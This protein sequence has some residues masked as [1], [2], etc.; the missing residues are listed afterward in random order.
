[1]KTIICENSLLLCQKVAID[2]RDYINAH[3]GSL[4]CL[5]AGDTP[6][7]AY[8][9]LI[10][11]AKNREVDLN[12]VFYVG[13]DEWLGI[14]IETRGSC[15]QVMQEN[16]YGP[17][18]IRLENMLLWD[19]LCKNPQEEINRVMK[20]VKMHGGID[21]VL[22]GIGMNGHIGLNEPGTDLVDGGVVTQLSETTIQV[23]KK[24][25]DAT[26]AIS[27]GLTLGIGELKKAKTLCLMATS[28][29]KS[30]IVHS[31][32]CGDQ[33]RAVP[34]SLLT[35]HPNSFFYLDSEAALLL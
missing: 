30:K 35:D 23:S 12:S 11:M 18:G 6:L 27:Q 10:D 8:R 17:A 7:L 1:M 14:G 32:L 16:F 19:G 13:L 31:V 2:L 25:F 29:R 3:P 5:A 20:F 26:I 15:L 34:A 28:A 22:L 24:Y 21:Y 4:L 33:K 9:L